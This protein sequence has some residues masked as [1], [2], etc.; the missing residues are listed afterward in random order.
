MI[1]HPRGTSGLIIRVKPV[2][3]NV[4]ICRP[5]CFFYARLL[6]TTKKLTVGYNN[7]PFNAKDDKAD[8]SWMGCH[9]WCISTNFW[10]CGTRGTPLKSSLQYA[11]IKE[12][13]SGF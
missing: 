7:H 2:F 1:V 12:I 5:T 13:A 3:F 6:L 11:S 10:I 4:K 9:F 8:T